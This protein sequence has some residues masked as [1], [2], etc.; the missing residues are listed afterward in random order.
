MPQLGR[1]LA[2]HDSAAAHQNTAAGHVACA[3]FKRHV[4]FLNFAANDN[5]RP[6]PMQAR[7]TV[8]RGG[9]G[10]QTR[11]FQDI[12]CLTRAAGP[13]Y[14]A[15]EQP[16]ADWGLRIAFTSSPRRQENADE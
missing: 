7:S 4:G 16:H 5:S 8:S 9:C 10:L 12:V 13:A 3:H 15:E 2:Q 11:L 1:L 6:R 14:S